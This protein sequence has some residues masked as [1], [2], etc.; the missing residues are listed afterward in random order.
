MHKFNAEY[1]YDELAVV[2][3]ECNLNEKLI[4]TGDLH[5]NWEYKCKSNKKK[6]SNQ[7]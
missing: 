3:K 2:L 6:K 1:F 4:L 5:A 7:I